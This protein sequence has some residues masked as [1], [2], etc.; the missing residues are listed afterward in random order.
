VIHRDFRPQQ[1]WLF[2]EEAVEYGCC[3]RVLDRAPDSIVRRVED[4]G[5]DEN[6][7]NSATMNDR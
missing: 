7:L 5:G 3:D 1:K 6:D 2:A 4:N